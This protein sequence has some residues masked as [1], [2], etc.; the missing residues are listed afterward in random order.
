MA[1]ILMIAPQPFFQPRGTPFS[2]RARI[3]ALAELGHTVELAT[4]G[5]GDDPGLPGLLIRRCPRPFW[6]K[7]VPIGPSG[8]KVVL[9]FLLF[10]TVLR[11]LLTRPRYDLLFT[12]EEASF[13]ALVLAPL[14]RLPHLYDMHSLLSEQLANFRKFNIKPLVGLFNFLETRVARG[15]AGMIAICPALGESARRMAAGTPLEVIENTYDVG[16]PPPVP[17]TEIE[18][19]RAETGTS[20][21]PFTPL[22]TGT[23][24]PYQG[25]DLLLAGWRIFA[26]GNPEARLV[27]V[28]G[29]PP[30]QAAV[31]AAVARLGIAASVRI[32]PRR[33]P[34][35]IH[36]WQAMA[37]CLLSTRSSGVNTPLKLYQALWSGKPI[38]A[39]DIFSHTQALT[40]ETALLV[41]PTPEGIAA[42]LERLAADP[43]LRERLGRA[44]RAAGEST[45][46][47]RVY[48]ERLGR[49]MAATLKRRDD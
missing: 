34:A 29:A 39:T 35:E 11:M 13:M 19:L 27:L 25:I 7:R 33:P 28:G 15:A 16:P 5:V 40:P 14:F 18:R 22:Y 38:L 2:V 49:L 37:D 43:E 41:P 48:L 20:G 10:F 8:A 12:H 45:F 23:F 9:D 30:H 42:G 31:E 24:E 32:V 3:A 6:I 36:A 44:G 26:G 46:N 4:Y 47:R 1:R 17:A 21:A